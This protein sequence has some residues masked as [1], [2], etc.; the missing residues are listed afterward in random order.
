MNLAKSVY[1]EGLVKPFVN[2]GSTIHPLIIPSEQTNGTGL[3]NPSVFVDG[4]KLLVNIRHVNY[5]LYHSENKKFQH[6]FGP[7]QYLNPENDI[8]L[9]TWNYLCELDDNIN[10]KTITKVDT[11]KFDVDP[12]WEFIGLEDARVFRWDDKLY[13]CGV[14]RD[15]TTHGE[16]RMELSEIVNN[17]EVR[18]TRVPTTG[19]NNTYCEKNWMPVIDQPFTWVKWTNPTELVRYDFKTNTTV[20]T[21]LDESTFKAGMPDFRGGSQVIPYGDYYIAITHEVNLIKPVVGQKD[22]TYRHRFVVWDKNW[23][24]IKFTEAFSFM[25]ADI[26]FCCG[27]AIYQGNF[28][29]SFGFQDNCAFILKA[30][31]RLIDELLELNTNTTPTMVKDNVT[32]QFDWGRIRDNVWFYN[33]VN[34]EVFVNDDYQ[35]YFRVEPNDVVVDIGASVGPFPWSIDNQQ[36]KKIICLEPNAEL[37]S[38]LSK[39]IQALNTEVVAINKGLHNSDGTNLL[40]GLFDPDE[41]DINEEK[42]TLVET[43]S[44]DTLRKQ[45]MLDQIDFFKL[46]CEGAEYDIF[47]DRNLDW[48]TNNVKKIAM[49]VHLHTP[50]QKAKFRHFRDTYLTKFPKLWVLSFDYVDIKKDLFTDWFI[51]YYSGIMIYIDNRYSTVELKKWQK[52]PAPTLEITTVIPAKGCTVDC[53]FCPQR[54]LEQTYDSERVLTLDN[55]KTLIDKVPQD[56]RITFAGFTEPWLNKYASDMVLYAND[57]SHPVSVFTTGVGMTVKDCER[58]V[59]VPYAGNPNG[60]FVLHLPDSELLAK[61]PITPTFIKTMEWFKLNHHRIKNFTTMCM[62][63]VHPDIKHLFDWAPTFSM[64]GRANNLMKETVLKPELIPLKDRWQAVYHVDGK[65]TCGCV[66]HLY[67][68]VLLPNGDISLCCMDYG[69]DNILGNLYKQEYVDIIP[70]DRTCYK[71]CNF[72]ENGIKPEEVQTC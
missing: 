53:V 58:I 23:N 39:N 52:Y 14:R 12:L 49:E 51:E 54:L 71:I 62:G 3:M 37:F 40:T 66:E 60:G 72:C 29:I 19:E 7:L 32:Y 13:L 65:R 64:Y 11:S 57:Q 1:F 70:K 47:T 44:F 43:I 68:N 59:D 6:K 67:H 38:T 61:H 36:A 63:Q 41:V 24:L 4:D 35:R 26:E 45:F 42:A 17:V 9:R 27:M 22:A 18:R 15:T 55:F 56:V 46:D 10:L 5:T 20:T 31:A 8:T 21:H 34:N 48:I 30:P 69:L 2:A 28:L 25:N 16:G 33:Q 50:E